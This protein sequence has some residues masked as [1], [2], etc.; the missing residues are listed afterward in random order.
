[1]ARSQPLLVEPQL[2]TLPLDGKMPNSDLP[3]VIYRNAVGGEDL[4]RVFR[5]LFTHK[6]WGG[7]W[8]DG[9]F[10]YNHFHSNAHEV[11]GVIDDTAMLVLGG[12]AGQEID[13]SRGDVLI[14]PAGTGHRRLRAG[15]DFLV[16]GA[17]PKGQ[18][19]FDIYVDSAL[20][21]NY[22]NRLRA[23]EM[24]SADP[25]FGKDG[26]LVSLWAERHI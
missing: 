18:E 8:T 19:R 11:L 25:L 13:I 24:P 7:L 10:G 26:P 6:G 23:V 15:Q 12:D 22:R 4:E 9:I 14:L 21:A 16:V 5:Q 1:M 3:V 17:Y 20:C 2:L